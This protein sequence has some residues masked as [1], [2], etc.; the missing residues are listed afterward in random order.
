M[1]VGSRGLRPVHPKVNH[2][3][4]IMNLPSHRQ[5]TSVVAWA[6]SSFP[7]IFPTR[8]AR[9]AGISVRLFPGDAGRLPRSWQRAPM[10]LMKSCGILSSS[11]VDMAGMLRYM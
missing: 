10:I 5:D 4:F 11:G 8:R 3:M 7:H 2:T 6:H 9:N 1:H